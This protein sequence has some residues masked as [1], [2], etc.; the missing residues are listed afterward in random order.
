MS[1]AQSRPL[2]SNLRSLGRI[3]AGDG[4]RDEMRS[5]PVIVVSRAGFSLLVSDLPT[6]RARLVAARRARRYTRYHHGR[7]LLAVFCS[8][9]HVTTVYRGQVCALAI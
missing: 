1:T 5:G 2:S 4:V 3:P 7:V 8:R 6:P 9:H